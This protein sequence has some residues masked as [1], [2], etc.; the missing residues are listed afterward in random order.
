MDA[1]VKP[2]HD[3]SF[4]QKQ[5]CGA[6]SDLIDR[7]PS[8]GAIPR[9]G[10]VHRAEDQQAHELRIARHVTVALEF[11]DHL[12]PQRVFLPDLNMVNSDR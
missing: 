11:V 3:E 7:E 5:P 2:A 10:P 8:A 12:L 9:P 4:V 1:R 6:V